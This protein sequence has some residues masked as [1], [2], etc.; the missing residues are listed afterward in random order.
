MFSSVIDAECSQLRPETE[1]EFNQDP[2]SGL[3]PL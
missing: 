1:E 3:D 2:L